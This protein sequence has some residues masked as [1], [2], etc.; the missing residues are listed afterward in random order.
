MK[1]TI[2]EVLLLERFQFFEPP[3]E[4]YEI[5]DDTNSLEKSFISQL[6]IKSEADHRKRNEV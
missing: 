4:V 6:R 2:R 5:N 1:S 3:P